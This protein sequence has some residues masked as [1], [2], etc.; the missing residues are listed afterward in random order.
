VAF[1]NS[2][3]SH[4]GDYRDPVLPVVQRGDRGRACEV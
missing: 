4:S 2:S 1:S 3:A